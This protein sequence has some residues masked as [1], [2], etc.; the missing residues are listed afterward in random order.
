[1]G[2]FEEIEELG[3]RMRAGE[4]VIHCALCG[5]RCVEE[6]H[7]S[8]QHYF[9]SSECV[10]GVCAFHGPLNARGECPGCTQDVLSGKST[11][12]SW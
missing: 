8:G 10:D 11:V 5:K 12:S 3:R 7:W 2:M 6:V 4:V 9:C 1:M